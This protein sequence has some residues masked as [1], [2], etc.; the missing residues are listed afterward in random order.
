MGH[1]NAKASAGLLC[2]LVVVAAC[3]FLSA[4]TSDYWQAWVFLA[5][6][7]GAEIAITVYLMKRDPRLLE[8]RVKAGPVAEKER[9]QRIIQL[10]A[11]V[12]FVGMMI[13]PGLDHR[14]GWSTVQ[15]WVSIGGDG[16]VLLGF[17]GV[18]LV[19]KENTY[20]SA[21]IEVGAEQRVIS[22]GPYAVVRHPMYSAALVMLAGVPLALGSWLGLLPVVP[23][24]AAIVVR[25]L[26]EERFLAT[27]LP[28]YRE[29]REKTRYRI[30]PFLW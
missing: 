12:G 13:L 9:R 3:L 26:D 29:Y 11:S 23:M 16:L 21:I 10:I 30:A 4:G 6:F 24:M 8:R 19:F 1:V 5:A 20:A 14:F 28:G 27:N 15:P 2:L 22:T 18:F 25:L 7:C 17:L